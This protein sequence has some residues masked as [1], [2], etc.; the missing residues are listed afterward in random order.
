MPDGARIELADLSDS[1]AQAV[2]FAATFQRQGLD[3]S[4]VLLDTPELHIPDAD[5]A[6][7]FDAV[8]RLGVNNQVIA[9]TS[10]RSILQRPGVAVIELGAS[11]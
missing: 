11:V 4:L 5:Q 3:D 1:E 9:A 7:F 10:S 8:C 6:A 2:L